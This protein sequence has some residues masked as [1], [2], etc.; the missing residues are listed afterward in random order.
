MLII[1]WTATTYA[2]N[3]LIIFLTQVSRRFTNCSP[4]VFSTGTFYKITVVN[5]DLDNL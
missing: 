2:R 5:H 4:T 1:L 3:L